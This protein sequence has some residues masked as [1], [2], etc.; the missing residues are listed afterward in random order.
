[1]KGSEPSLVKAIRFLKTPTPVLNFPVASKPNV[2]M[3][4]T[5]KCKLVTF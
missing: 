3:G 2:M 1:M 5:I 4:V